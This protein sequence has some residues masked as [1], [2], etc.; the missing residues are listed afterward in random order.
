[1]TL[2]LCVTFVQYTTSHLCNN[3]NNNNNNKNN[4]AGQDGIAL[5]VKSAEVTEA[6]QGPDHPALARVYATIGKIYFQ[7]KQRDLAMKCVRLCVCVCACERLLV[8]LVVW[9]VVVVV[10]LVLCVAVR[11]N[12][13]H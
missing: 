2:G 3:N 1:M 9:L 10:A 8:R 4:N 5:Y 12:S 6:L 13:S 11:V 7:I